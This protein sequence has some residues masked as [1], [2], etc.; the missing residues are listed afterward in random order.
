M[1][2]TRYI[3][4]IVQGS[5]LGGLERRYARL[6]EYLI[7]CK[8]EVT[9]FTTHEAFESLV[10]SGIQISEDKVKFIDN[11]IVSAVVGKNFSMKIGFFSNFIFRMI[12]TS[13]RNHVH[14]VHDPGKVSS[15]YS[16]FSKILPPFSITVAD[17]RH[18]YSVDHLK[19]LSKASTIDC[20]SKS[21][22]I[23]L[24]SQFLEQGMNDSV[25]RIQISPCSFAD[26]PENINS[27]NDREID[28]VFAG[29]FTKGK[30]LDLLSSAHIDTRVIDLHVVGEP[31]LPPNGFIPEIPGAKIYFE[32]KLNSVLLRTKIFLSIQEI[33]NYPSQSLLEAMG[34]GCAIIATNVGE[35]N[36]LIDEKC[37]LLISY[38]A[39]SL[40]EAIHFLYSNPEVCQEFGQNA[41][42]KA[43]KFFTVQRFS[44]YFL[45]SVATKISN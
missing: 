23:K 21:I 20:L 42:D 19:P 7:K 8:R 33:E 10:L 13:H 41:S 6:I 17:S 37:G 22:A 25:S 43:R 5:K 9:L 36:K 4:A 35:T 26:Y 1:K 27:W 12:L 28:V 32:P 3:F 24:S 18:S 14:L 11:K 45:G 31:G 40:E 16:F 29:R 39:K 2:Q 15:T 34:A 38:D 30:G 44:E